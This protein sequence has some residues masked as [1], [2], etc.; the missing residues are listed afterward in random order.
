MAFVGA[1]TIDQSVALGRPIS[2]DTR[3]R[4][5]P[6]LFGL[7]WLTIPWLRRLN[8]KRAALAPTRDLP[9]MGVE[10]GAESRVVIGM[11]SDP[12][13]VRDNNEDRVRVVRPANEGVDSDGLLAVVCDG[14]GDHAAGETAS[15]IATEV[16]ARDYPGRDDPGAALLRA[17]R[18]ANRAVHDAAG[19]DPALTGMGTTC[20]AMVLRGGLAWCAHVGDSRCYLV[21]DGEIFVMTEDHRAVMA[22]VRNGSISR[23]EARDHPDRNVLSRALGSHRDIEVTSWPRPFVIRPGDRF[24]LSTDGLHDVIR[25]EEILRVVRTGRPHEACLELVRLARE[26]GAPD[27]VSVLVLALPDSDGPGTP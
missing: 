18:H 7:A 11:A 4:P 23:D 5:V 26:H 3:P 22:L 27:N 19:R 13:C 1:E 14:M 16:I 9:A 12:G 24:L 25:E 10:L 20:T 17:I 21:R 15:R 2:S 8:A 6:P